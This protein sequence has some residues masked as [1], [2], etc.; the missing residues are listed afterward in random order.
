MTQLFFLSGLPRTGSTLLASIL[1]QHPQIFATGT[2]PLMDLLFL[3][4]RNLSNLRT[5]Y[6]LD[7]EIQESNIYHAIIESF[8]KHVNKPIVFDKH[9]GWPR[10]AG[11]LR[12]FIEK[13]KIVCTVRPIA[14]IIASYLTLILKHPMDRN[15]IDRQLNESGRPLTIEN[16]AMLIWEG[17]VQDPYQS[18]IVGLRDNPQLMLPITYNE[19]TTKPNESLKKIFDFCTIP[20]YKDFNFNHLYNA[21]P[22]K[23]EEGWGMPE[24]HKIRPELKALSTP[25]RE[26][27]GSALTDYFKQF[28]LPV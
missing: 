27:L 22:E 3:T 14:E 10:N 25:P 19:I 15:F 17:Y 8:Y 2:S 9:R 4:D 18:M 12:R 7:N 20:I 26:I 23:D 24:L 5:Q 28:D 1:N 11:T 13:P 21:T 6:I 16:R